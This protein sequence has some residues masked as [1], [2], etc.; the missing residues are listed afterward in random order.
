LLRRVFHNPARKFALQML[1]FDR[2]VGEN[3]LPLG[4]QHAC[5]I[6]CATSGLWL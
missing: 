5:T 4:A 3:G 2:A 6:S 1:D